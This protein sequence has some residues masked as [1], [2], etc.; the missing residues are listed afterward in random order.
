MKWIHHIIYGS[1]LVS[2]AAWTSCGT[3][4]NRTPNRDTP[5]PED[6]EA[7]K[8]LQGI[9]IDQET[10]TV[11]FCAKGD[12]IYYPDTANVPVRFLS[13]RTLCFWPEE[14]IRPLIP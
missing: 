12:T 2:V 5:E 4:D 6:Q 7:K 3:R 14:A 8:A 10:E 1:L 13:V 11:S 9:W